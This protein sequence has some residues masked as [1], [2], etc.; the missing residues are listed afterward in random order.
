MPSKSKSRDD[1]RTDLSNVKQT[2]VL[3]IV[4]PDNAFQIL[5]RTDRAVPV[6]PFS[7]KE[8]FS[9]PLFRPPMLP[10]FV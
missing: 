3:N 8:I 6:A 2:F 10:T 4:R 9:D 7:L 1:T 5:A